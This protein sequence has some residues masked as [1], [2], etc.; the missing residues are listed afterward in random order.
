MNG[1][2]HL[3]ALEADATR[4]VELVALADQSAPVPTCPGWTEIRHGVV[5]NSVSA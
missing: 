5:H 2:E 3:A 4:L 1:V